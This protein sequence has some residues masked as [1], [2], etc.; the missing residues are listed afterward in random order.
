MRPAI[1]LATMCLWALL[2]AAVPPPAQVEVGRLLPI[3][4]AAE[5]G[6]ELRAIDLWNE[7]ATVE[8]L[9]VDPAGPIRFRHNTR[10]DPGWGWAQGSTEQVC[11]V[12]HG[13]ADPDVALLIHELG[14]CLGFADSLTV[15]AYAD[16]RHTHQGMRVCD[17]PDHPAYSPYAGIMSYC[18]YQLD[19]PAERC[20]LWRLGYLTNRQYASTLTGWGD[21]LRCAREDR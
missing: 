16:P 2:A 10:L 20:G 3:G 5:T 4:V 14:H 7:T 17:D 12:H 13:D 1:I 21:Y 18:T 8:L 15:D 9:V 19:P 6:A 11:T